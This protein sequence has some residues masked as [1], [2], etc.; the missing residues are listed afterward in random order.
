[1]LTNQRE[2]LNL[3]LEILVSWLPTQQLEPPPGNQ[4][5]A[6]IYCVDQSE[7][8]IVSSQSLGQL[9]SHSKYGV[10][11]ELIAEHH[12]VTNQGPGFIVLTN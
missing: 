6:W 5:E 4:S 9:A 11:I 12:Q 8:R 7:T 2:E 3:L 1:M 10:S